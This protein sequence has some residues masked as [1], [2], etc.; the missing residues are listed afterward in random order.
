MATPYLDLQYAHSPRTYALQP[1][2]CVHTYTANGLRGRLH[3]TGSP[4]V[5]PGQMTAELFKHD[6]LANQGLIGW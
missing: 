2:F 1:S 3:S 5:Q 6:S 4:S